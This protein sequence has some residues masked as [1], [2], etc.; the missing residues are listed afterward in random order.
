MRR[1]LVSNTDN[2]RRRSQ[3]QLC[4][5]LARMLW[6]SS[7]EQRDWVT[8]RVNC[9]VAKTSGDTCLQP[10]RKYVFKDF[11]LRVDFLPGIAEC[12]HQEQ[13][14]QAVMPEHFECQALPNR[15]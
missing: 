13:L 15:C 12:L 2:P 5:R 10:F 3:R 4:K 8:M 6:D 1:I 9:R 7:V 11:C 14:H